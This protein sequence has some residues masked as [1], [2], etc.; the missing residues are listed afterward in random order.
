M[1]AEGL[2][3]PDMSWSISRHTDAGVSMTRD[4][5]CLRFTS[6]AHELL[7]DAPP[8][9]A[10]RLWPA[11]RQ[12]SPGRPCT[13]GPF[14]FSDRTNHRKV[15]SAVRIVVADCQLRLYPI[16]HIL[17]PI[18]QWEGPRWRRSQSWATDANAASTS[19]SRDVPQPTSLGPVLSARAPTGIG[20]E[21]LSKT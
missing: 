3:V 14:A 7:P 9:L 16:R 10:K 6:R 1:C 2:R 17:K 21:R 4:E 13:C 8:S 5:G 19:G 20:Q 15:Q 11:L 18:S 12:P